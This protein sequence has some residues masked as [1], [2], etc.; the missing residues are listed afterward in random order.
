[1]NEND[2]EIVYLVRYSDG[3]IEL[4]HRIVRPYVSA[5]VARG[6]EAT[7]TKLHSEHKIECFSMIGEYPA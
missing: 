6:I 5:F 3:S 1:M 7:L 2:V 4:R